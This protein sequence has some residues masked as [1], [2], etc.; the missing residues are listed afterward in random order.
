MLKFLDGIFAIINR[1]QPTKYMI[2]YRYCNFPNIGYIQAVL[3]EE[4]IKPIK[5]EIN[6]IINNNYNSAEKF[7]Y[8]LAGNINKEYKLEKNSSDQIYC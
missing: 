7:N 2:N 1:K 6:S 8:T 3:S 5:D 4:Q